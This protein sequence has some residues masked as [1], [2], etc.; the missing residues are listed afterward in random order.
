[1]LSWALGIAYAAA[2]WLLLRRIMKKAVQQPQRAGKLVAWGL[3]GR[4]LLTAAVLAVALLL[5]GLEPLGVVVPLI[6]Q[7][8]AAVVWSLLP[9]RGGPEKLG[10]REEQP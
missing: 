2:D 3:A 5:P 10:K 9:S 6:L 8:V 4:Y 1:M 7:K